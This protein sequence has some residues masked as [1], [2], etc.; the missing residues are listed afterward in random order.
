MNFLIQS[1]NDLEAGQNIKLL[2][3]LKQNKVDEAIKFMEV[4]VKF[5]LTRDGVTE[6]TISKAK[7]Y[8]SSYCQEDCLG[9]SK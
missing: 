6:S 7:Q 5:S 9:T 2:E 4:R 1:D 8:Q 3:A